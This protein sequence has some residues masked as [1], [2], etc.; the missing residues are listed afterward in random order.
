MRG[1]NSDGR[2]LYD[3]IEDSRNHQGAVEKGSMSLLSW[4]HGMRKR[5]PSDNYVVPDSKA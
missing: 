2:V 5:K 4:S 3:A 1:R